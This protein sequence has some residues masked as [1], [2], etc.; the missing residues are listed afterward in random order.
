METQKL[1][2]MSEISGLKLR[3]TSTERENSELREGAKHIQY[4]IVVQ[5][6]KVHYEYTLYRQQSTP[7]VSHIAKV[8]LK[9]A[10]YVVQQ[11]RSASVTRLGDL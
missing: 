6:S 4:S 3:Q 11:S 10:K 9:L 2:L 7:I 8:T 5:Y 1:E